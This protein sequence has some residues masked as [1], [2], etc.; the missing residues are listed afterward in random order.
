MITNKSIVLHFYKF[1][2]SSLISKFLTEKNGLQSV[3][4]RNANSKKS[5]KNI[6]LL[7]PLNI[8][9]LVVTN[10][11]KNKL[12]FVKEINYL[13]P[14]NLLLTN[15]SSKFISMFVS[16]VLI[17]VL[18]EGNKDSELFNFI[19]QQSIIIN[20]RI[21]DKNY[22]LIFLT[23][24]SSYLGFYPNMENSHFPYFDMENAC[25][26]KS[27]ASISI[28]GKEKEMFLKL[29][30]NDKVLIPY[31]LR[32]SLMKCIANYYK[33]QN[34]NLEPLKSYEIIESLRRW[35]EYY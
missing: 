1:S 4:I 31:D 2:K 13:N 11:K 24:L 32:K 6:S 10:E 18:I 30:N 25:F 33:L 7:H 9:N 26:T 29:L 23:Q 20:N 21:L 34:F 17:K 35:V 8:V 27:K 3:V 5:N 15:M 12:Q 19:E 28:C 14:L 16:E 22:P